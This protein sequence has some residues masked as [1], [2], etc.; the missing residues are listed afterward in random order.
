MSHQ[1]ESTPTNVLTVPSPSKNPAISCGI[2][3]S[4]LGKNHSLAISAVDPL[5]SNP[6]LTVTWKPMGPVSCNKQRFDCMCVTVHFDGDWNLFKCFLCLVFMLRV[7]ILIL[8]VRNECSSR[9]KYFIKICAI[10]QTWKNSAAIFV[11]PD[12]RPR[13]AWKF[14]CVSTLEPSLSSV[15]TVT[16]GSGPQVIVRA[17]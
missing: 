16:W 6:L 13:E 17:T 8:S 10:F 15:H 14:T 5:L 3:E 12:F 7:K 2:S 9:K 4:T 1:G 11:A